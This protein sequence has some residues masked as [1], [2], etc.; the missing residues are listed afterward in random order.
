LVDDLLDGDWLYAVV[1]GQRLAR[2]VDE[3]AEEVVEA[4]G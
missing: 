3:L 2:A 4:Y 1:A